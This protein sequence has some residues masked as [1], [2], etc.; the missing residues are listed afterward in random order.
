MV[1][2]KIK[3]K[4]K[5]SRRTNKQRRNNTKKK[6]RVKNRTRK[7]GRGRN[8]TQYNS[9]K[10]II[11][12]GKSEVEINKITGEVDNAKTQVVDI[13]KDEF[14]KVEIDKAKRLITVTDTQSDC[15]EDNKYMDNRSLILLENMVDI[16]HD[17]VAEG[18][19]SY[20]GLL[21]V[22]LI[23]KSY[24]ALYDYDEE[25]GWELLNQEPKIKKWLLENPKGEGEEDDDDEEMEEEKEEQKFKRWYNNTVKAEAE[26]FGKSLELNFKNHL[27]KNIKNK[28]L[29]N[30][31]Y[32]SE[33]IEAEI[34][35]HWQYANTTDRLVDVAPYGGGSI[36]N[37][38]KL[39]EYILGRGNSFLDHKLENYNWVEESIPIPSVHDVNK[40]NV[41][42]E[43]VL[44]FDTI[45][46]NYQTTLNKQTIKEEEEEEEEEEDE[47]EEVDEEEEE[48]EEGDVTMSESKNQDEAPMDNVKINHIQQY[49][50]FYAYIFCKQIDSNNEKTLRVKISEKNKIF[51]NF[52]K[53]FVIK[54]N[55]RLHNFEDSLIHP[56]HI[57]FTDA[58]SKASSAV[59]KLYELMKLRGIIYDTYS[60]NLPF[61]CRSMGQVCDMATGRVGQPVALGNRKPMCNEDNEIIF[62]DALLYAIEVHQRNTT[63]KYGIDKTKFVDLVVKQERETDNKTE[64][65]IEFLKGFKT[66]YSKLLNDIRMLYKEY[67]AT[68]YLLSAKDTNDRTLELV[69]KSEITTKDLVK[70]KF[71]HLM[72]YLLF[73]SEIELPGDE[74]SSS[75]SSFG[76]YTDEQR[77]LYDLLE[78]EKLLTKTNQ[79]NILGKKDN[80]AE[81][82]CGAKLQKAME[83]S[84][85]NGFFSQNKDKNFSLSD[86]WNTWGDGS[87]SRFY[88]DLTDT[89]DQKSIE[90]KKENRQ[91]AI[92]YVRRSPF[93]RASVQ[94]LSSEIIVDVAQKKQKKNITNPFIKNTSVKVK[95]NGIYLNKNFTR[96]NVAIMKE[97]FSTDFTFENM[98]E[99]LDIYN[100][101]RRRNFTNCDCRTE[102]PTDFDDAYLNGLDDPTKLKGICMHVNTRSEMD[103]GGH[104]I[105]SIG[106]KSAEKRDA[107]D[108]TDETPP[109]PAV[110][111]GEFISLTD[112]EHFR[113][114]RLI[115]LPK[116]VKKTKKTTYTVKLDLL[117]ANDPK[118]TKVKTNYIRKLPFLYEKLDK[119]PVKGVSKFNKEQ[120]YAFIKKYFKKCKNFVP[121][122]KPGDSSPPS[123][124]P[125]DLAYIYRL[126]RNKPSSDNGTNKDFSS[127]VKRDKYTTKEQEVEE[128]EGNK[129]AEL[130][131]TGEKINE[132]TI[133]GDTLMHDANQQQQQPKDV[134]MSDAKKQEEEER[135]DAKEKCH[136][137]WKTFGLMGDNDVIK[138][139]NLMK[140]MIPN[141]F[142]LLYNC[143]LFDFETADL[144]TTTTFAGNRTTGRLRTNEFSKVKNGLTFIQNTINTTIESYESIKNKIK[145]KQTITYKKIKI[146]QEQEVEQEVI[147]F[148]TSNPSVTGV[149]S[150]VRQYIVYC[151]LKSGKLRG[152]LG[153]KLLNNKDF[154]DIDSRKEKESKAVQ[155]L[156]NDLIKDFMHIDS[157]F[158]GGGKIVKKPTV[159]NTSVSRRRRGRPVSQPLI[160]RLRGP[161]RGPPRG[162]RPPIKPP[163]GNANNQSGRD[164]AREKAAR[165]RV[166][167]AAAQKK[168]PVKKPVKE[169]T[170]GKKRKSRTVPED[171]GEADAAAEETLRSKSQRTNEAGK[172]IIYVEETTKLGKDLLENIDNDI[173]VLSCNNRFAVVGLLLNHKTQGDEM[174]LH[175]VKAYKNLFTLDKY[176]MEVLYHVYSYDGV[177]GIKALRKGATLLFQSDRGIQ[178]SLEAKTEGPPGY[179]R[180]NS[181]A[182]D[183]LIPEL[184]AHRTPLDSEDDSDSGSE[185]D[186]QKVQ[187]EEQEEEDDDD[188]PVEGFE[189]LVV[190][191]SSAV[192]ATELVKI[193]TW[194]SNNISSLYDDISVLT[195]DTLSV[196]QESVNSRYESLIN[197]YK[198]GISC[199]KSILN[200]MINNLDQNNKK[201]FYKNLSVFYTNLDDFLDEC[202]RPDTSL[203]TVAAAQ[204]RIKSDMRKIL[205]PPINLMTAYVLKDDENLELILQGKSELIKTLEYLQFN[206]IDLNNKFDEA[207]NKL[208]QETAQ[209][210]KGASIDNTIIT[211]EEIAFL[212]SNKKYLVIIKVLIGY[213][214]NIDLEVLADQKR[215]LRK[216]KVL[217]KYIL[218]AITKKKDIAQIFSNIPENELGQ[219]QSLARTSS[220]SPSKT[221]TGV[222]GS[223]VKSNATDGEYPLVDFGE[224]LKLR[225]QKIISAADFASSA[226]LAV[227]RTKSIIEASISLPTKMRSNMDTHKK[228]QEKT[229]AQNLELT[230]FVKVQ[231]SQ[232]IEAISELVKILDKLLKNKPCK[233]I[234]EKLSEVDVG[235]SSSS[236]SSS[237]S[238][239]E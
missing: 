34:L 56:I 117:I 88:L 147:T 36:R 180:L 101:W 6:Y 176:G 31:T 9:T 146:D 169:K 234:M 230:N 201:L 142:K 41:T 202:C 28:F 195:R 172:A 174:Q 25:E 10:I 18:N 72:N 5:Y 116:T 154:F 227:D 87:K 164:Q 138:K 220:Q 42:L 123:Y 237:S 141:V 40:Y 81:T 200:N 67:I 126:L 178:I 37:G 7:N 217:F 215:T 97:Y 16:I 121:E 20:N 140:N 69:L 214:D 95:A 196:T 213:I 203:E 47:D 235:S 151:L 184:S 27:Y 163:S 153:N 109:I 12:G 194:T 177:M 183:P 93:F 61:E 107:V 238:D 223:P 221:T 162:P 152:D 122:K 125:L 35:T 130:V 48:G 137:F 115:I 193:K 124:L 105:D 43:E 75:S 187:N 211:E 50:I 77:E 171:G 150:N 19:L 106:Y 132:D 208:G 73:L 204:E 96:S 102:N 119:K 22:D 21:S 120:L 118:R 74:S 226:A 1:S 83:S 112:I 131:P 229:S 133:D 49:Y 218:I 210:A 185:E 89:N 209:E 23:V 129:V 91:T 186:N 222:T 33:G 26:S 157:S 3:K 45:F 134:G 79:K 92:E 100:G 51:G 225:L 167:K 103:G 207:K 46:K 148:S 158:S 189:Q 228:L 205:S 68:G 99:A 166:E 11:G 159:P 212:N 110:E 30:P 144:I 84:Y 188:D 104:P 71:F 182:D 90:K 236:S 66:I 59:P 161:P 64:R 24:T 197:T 156:T 17:V 57:N 32:T 145:G 191:N 149:L 15:R 78:L 108:A 76:T 98:D 190:K 52:E 231:H 160:R 239:E 206:L 179:Q 39:W 58:T 219:N 86:H 233:E 155:E 63:D 128:E 113:Y 111:K 173:Q 192:D 168:K 2:L 70:L 55:N 135:W 199:Y 80:L 65:N 143:L 114:V 62:D 54:R 14:Y 198:K 82:E 232:N 136:N 85:F 216:I 181:K 127:L 165:A 224:Y 8:L 53:L 38:I 94:N 13:M 60:D 175:G 44:N 170:K 4:R 29:M 139:I